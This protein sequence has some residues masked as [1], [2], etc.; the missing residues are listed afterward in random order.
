M[1]SASF[2]RRIALV[3]ALAVAGS[4]A[5]VAGITAWL[6]NR[7]ALADE[8]ARLTEAAHSLASELE[9]EGQDAPA[10]VA[11]EAAERAPA[12]IAIAAYRHGV[13][14]ADKRFFARKTRP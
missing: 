11:E 10:I 9:S 3:T 5:S 14:L 7:I 8:D 6:T 1:K 12:G 2:A 4:G 13:L